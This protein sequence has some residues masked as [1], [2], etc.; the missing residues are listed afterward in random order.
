MRPQN[1]LTTVPIGALALA[2]AGHLV[3]PKLSGTDGLLVGRDRTRSGGPV[4]YVCPAC[5]SRGILPLSE[6]VQDPI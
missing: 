3:T 5:L 4:P 2:I 1:P 6:A